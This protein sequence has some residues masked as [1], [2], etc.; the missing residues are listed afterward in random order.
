MLLEAQPE[1]LETENVL[2][3]VYIH[4]IRISVLLYVTK[5]NIYTFFLLCLF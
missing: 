4:S 2:D 3:D 1:N 5:K